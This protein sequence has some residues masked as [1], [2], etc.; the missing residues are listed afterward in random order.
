LT[1]TSTTISGFLPNTTYYWRVKGLTAI[2]ESGFWSS[3]FNFYSSTVSIK[4]ISQQIPKTLFLKPTGSSISYGLPQS[5]QIS[6]KLYTLQGQLAATLYSGSQEP[7]MYSI[8][9][10]AQSL[11]KARYIVQLKAG[12]QIITKRF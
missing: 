8:K 5:S 6:I 1:S 7:G 11:A 4:P 9:L 12:N 2:G 3:A 10:P